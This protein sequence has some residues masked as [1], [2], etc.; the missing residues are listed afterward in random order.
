MKDLFVALFAAVVIAGAAAEDGDRRGIEI[1]EE[2]AEPQNAPGR[3][4]NAF[5]VDLYARLAAEDGNVFVSPFSVHAALAMT[6]AGARGQTAEQMATTLHVA[7]TDNVHTA[8]GQ[9][10]K[11][12]NAPP[13]IGL[14]RRVGDRLERVMVPAYDLVVA[15]ALWGQQGYPWKEPFL[16]LTATHYGAGLNEVDFAT[17]A[18]E[19]R[20]KLNAWIEKRTN[21]KIQEL[22]QPGVLRPTTRLVL[23]NAV[24]L[25]ASWRDDFPKSATREAPFHV[26]AGKQVK[27]PLMH[28]KERH[29]Y[30]QTPT[31]QAL[32]MAYKGGDLTMVV[33]LPRAVDGLDALEKS[34][35]AKRL[36]GWLNRLETH[37]VQVTLPKFEFTGRYG[38]SK[39]LRQLG[40][41]DAFTAAADFSGMSAREKLVLSGVIHQAYVAVDEEGTE[42]A[43]ATAVMMVGAEMHGDKP[44]P[45]VFTADHPFLFLVRHRPTGAILFMGRVVNPVQ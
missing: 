4:A 11:R 10:L 32:E 31:L 2:E 44:E 8:Y 24:Y 13:K 14:H 9:V 20:V 36:Y 23:T 18:G 28:Q 27:A 37:E 16:D 41:V 45:K 5:A 19:A 15:N 1:T 26:A 40:M 35:T 43:A 12:L 30:M 33:L 6:Y 38:L 22:I 21:A 25:K 17:D 3:A 29:G 42:A 34:L 7:G 39:A